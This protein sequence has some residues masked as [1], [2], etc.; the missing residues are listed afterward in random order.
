M[1]TSSEP[2]LF[3]GLLQNR[4]YPLQ[5]DYF[6]SLN[7]FFQNYQQDHYIVIESTDLLN[8]GEYAIYHGST[9]DNETI[10]GELE[11]IMNRYSK[12]KQISDYTFTQIEYYSQ[13]V[14]IDVKKITHILINEINAQKLINIG[15]DLLQFRKRGFLLI[16]LGNLTQKEGT[17]NLEPTEEVKEFDAWLRIKLWEFDY[18]SIRDIDTYFPIQRNLYQ[19]KVEL[20]APFLVIFGS[21]EGTDIIYDIF[22]GFEGNNSLRSFYFSPNVIN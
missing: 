5:K 1:N 2:A 6:T 18:Y 21:L 9:K 11:S 4:Q 22:T 3:V 15:K 19:E 20:Y 8:T 7:S 12:L 16:G 13:A 10:I 14:N 17:G